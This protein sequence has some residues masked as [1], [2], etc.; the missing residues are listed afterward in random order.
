MSP[1]PNSGSSDPVS[2]SA[3]GSSAPSRRASVEQSF[4]DIYA[5]L[6]PALQLLLDE[7][8]G[9]LPIEIE[10]FRHQVVVFY[11]A[12]VPQDA[13]EVLQVITC[14]VQAVE[15]RRYRRA[16]AQILAD[17]AKAVMRATIGF[18]T[19]AP[20]DATQQER[21]AIQAEAATTNDALVRDWMRGDAKARRLVGRLIEGR[22]T[23]AEVLAMASDIA[24][25]QRGT[26]AGLAARAEAAIRRTQRDIVWRR[27][28]K[29]LMAKDGWSEAGPGNDN[30]PL[31]MTGADHGG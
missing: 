21:E 2:R 24:M 18:D 6:T 1:K 16:E 14:A 13:L 20:A 8:A 30:R 31:A 26:L 29:R 9:L 15:A 23:E 19:F 11:E 5:S 7:P 3:A 28:I 17:R 27:N 25:E 4:A 10:D 22:T 12:I